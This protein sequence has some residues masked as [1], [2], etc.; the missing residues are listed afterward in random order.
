MRV[1][2]LLVKEEVDDALST[3]LKEV[4][5]HLVHQF[6]DSTTAGD[7]K[8]SWQ[9]IIQMMPEDVPPLDFDSFKQMYDMQPDWAHLVRSFDD[10]FITLNTGEEVDVNM[11]D[12]ENLQEPSQNVVDDMAKRAMKKRI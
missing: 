6:K 7:N 12:P 8:I 3:A 9:A 2:E 4:L 1:S 11:A 10:E 5:D